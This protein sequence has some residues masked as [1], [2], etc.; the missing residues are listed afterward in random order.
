[1]TGQQVK[2]LDGI[3]GFE[4]GV[5]GHKGEEFVI[6]GGEGEGVVDLV[7]SDE[8]V[9]EETDGDGGHSLE[10]LLEIPE[11]QFSSGHLS[12]VLY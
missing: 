6:E 1:V 3:L 5:F 11:D 7:G 12:R 9:E 2:H 4:F 8:G 10:E